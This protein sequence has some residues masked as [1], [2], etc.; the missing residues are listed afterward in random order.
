MSWWRKYRNNCVRAY[1]LFDKLHL[2]LAELE[3]LSGLQHRACCVQH[4][5]P[6]VQAPNLHQCLWTHMQVCRSKRLNCHTD[7]YTVSWCCIRGES[8]DHTSEKACKGS[9]LVLKPRAMPP[10]VQ[11]RGI[12]GPMKRTYVPQKK[13]KKRDNS[14]CILQ[15]WPGVCKYTEQLGLPTF[16]ESFC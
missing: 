12:S 5:W 4:G 10:E 15:F 9:T 2:Y 8:E 11:N 1:V 7:L 13:F 6:W 3:W 16:K 14:I